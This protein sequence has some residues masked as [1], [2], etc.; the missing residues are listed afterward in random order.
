M[1]SSCPITPPT[2]S[3]KR[4]FNPDAPRKKR[5]STELNYVTP[6]KNSKC[7]TPSA[8]RKEN[9]SICHYT[10][11]KKKCKIS[12]CNCPSQKEIYVEK[13]NKMMIKIL[14]LKV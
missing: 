6:I 8:P 12:L 9:M 11:P 10:T 2:K 5:K 14:K 3:C 13:K 7:S 1:P 4:R